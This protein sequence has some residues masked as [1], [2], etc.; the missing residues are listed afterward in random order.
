M[1]PVALVH[2]YVVGRGGSERVLVSM[3][4]AF[5]RAPIHTAF[6]CPDLTFPELADADVRP[7]AIDRVP[8][9]RTRHRFALPV[10]APVFGRA[11]VDAA[12]VVCGTS[13]WAAGVQVPARKVAFVHAPARWLNDQDAFLA[14]RPRLERWGLHLLERRL[15][16]WDHRAMTSAHRHLAP[17]RAIAEQLAAIYGVRAEVLPPPVAIDPGGVATAPRAGLPQDFVLCPARLVTNKNVDVVLEAF[18]ARPHDQLVVAGDGPEMSRLRSLAPP[19]ALLLG[20]VDDAGMRWLYAACRAVVSAAHESFGLI[21]VEAAAFGRPS[22]ALRYGG[23]L[24]TVVD[25]QTGVLYDEPSAGAV[26]DALDRL[27]ALALPAERLRRHAEQW[28]ETAFIG[29]L[30]AVVAEEAALAR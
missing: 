9:L 18:R 15:R 22:L 21:T 3:H 20:A 19:N 14:G 12:V 27:D 7:F 29:R 4:R 10:L 25:G 5:P 16:A 26:N 13:G 1:E 17:S 6:S 28:S 23:A 8:G 30:Q 2:D 11:R 24:D